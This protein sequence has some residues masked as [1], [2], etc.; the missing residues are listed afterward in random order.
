MRFLDAFLVFLEKLRKEQP[1][2]IVSGDYNICHKAIDINHPERHN[3]YSGFLPEEREWMDKLVATGM[4]DSFRQ[5][6]QQAAQYSWWS[7]RAGA[8]SKNLG[9]RIDYHMVSEPIREK[10][11]NAFI[12]PQVLFSD[13]CPVGV[14][15]D[16]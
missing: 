3:D 15:I 9:W 1:N 12:M 4:V 10:L 7:Y 13:H 6:N 16:E 14:E 8:K 11:K 2:V 5:F